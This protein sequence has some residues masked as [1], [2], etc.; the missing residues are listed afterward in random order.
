MKRIVVCLL[1]TAF[2][3]TLWACA[4]KRITEKG[5]QHV[6]S[7]GV[8]QIRV[9]HLPE[10][11]EYARTY[12]DPEKIK[13]VT[14][15]I[16]SLTLDV[17]FEENPDE[18]SGSTWEITCT[19]TDGTEIILYHFGNLF[20]RVTGNEWRKMDAAQAQAFADL[21]GRYASDE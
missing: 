12:K 4:P 21:I 1:L 7:T 3:L 18:Y 14:D 11:P 5:S 2:C 17:L 6:P 8:S 20:F 15:Y 19:Y 16:D 13:A 9:R 10:S